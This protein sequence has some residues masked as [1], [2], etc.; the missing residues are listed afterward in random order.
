M[1]DDHRAYIRS[2]P[3]MRFVPHEFE[4]LNT[5]SC[6]L[7]TGTTPGKMWRRLDGDHDL[8]FKR[9]GGKP[10][11]MVGQYDPN[12]PADATEIEIH[13]YRPVIVLTADFPSV[14]TRPSMLI[15]QGRDVMKTGKTYLLGSMALSRA[16]REW[17]RER[18]IEPRRIDT[19]RITFYRQNDALEFRMR[20]S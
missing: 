8:A 17:M 9:R 12:C 20:W 15:D 11:W 13:W 7:P 19:K 14:P 18:G 4:K 6:S 16:V 1:M 5:Y 10:I 2:L 3:V